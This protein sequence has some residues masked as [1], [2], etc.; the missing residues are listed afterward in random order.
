MNTKT[1][2]CKKCKKRYGTLVNDLCF[3]CN[4]IG[5]KKHFDKIAGIEK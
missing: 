4:P 5:W 3:K 1:N 2:Q